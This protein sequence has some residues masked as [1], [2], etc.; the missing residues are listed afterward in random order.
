MM[1]IVLQD[2]L[3]DDPILLPAPTT[4]RVVLVIE[5]SLKKKQLR[6]K[7]F[8]SPQPRKQLSL[9]GLRNHILSLIHI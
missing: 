5:Q 6:K 9:T 4:K 2:G 3:P 8:P 7:D 1:G